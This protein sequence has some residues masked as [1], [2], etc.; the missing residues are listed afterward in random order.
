MIGMRERLKILACFTLFWLAF[1]ILIKAIFL[2]YN[3][4]LTRQLTASEIFLVFLYGL[5]MDASMSGYLLMF[6]S[7][8]LTISVFTKSKAIIYIIN[9]V[10]ILFLFIS[11]AVVIVDVELYRHWGFRL[12]TTPLLYIGPEA[13]GSIEPSVIIKNILILLIL[14]IGFL[15]IYIT[16]LIP[17]LHKLNKYNWKVFSIMLVITGLLFIPIRG[18]FTVAPMNTGFVYFHNTKPYANHAA[19]NVVWNFLKSVTRGNE[20]RYPENFF[21]KKLATTYF[22]ELYTQGDSTTSLLNTRKPNILLFVLESFTADV[23]EPLG[24]VKDITPN[25]NKLCREGILFDNFYASGDRTDK[26]IVSILSGYP[27]QPQSSIIKFPSKTQHL[28]YLTRYLNDLGYHTSFVYGGDIDFSN[29]RSYLTNCQFEHITSLDDLPDELYTS[30]W[31]IHD[32]YVFGQA[33]QE[34][35]SSK[36]PFFKIVLSL[37]SHEPFDV[38]MEPVIKGSDHESLFLNSCY[39]TDKSLGDFINKAKQQPWWSN[40]LVIITADHG[41]RLPRNKEIKDK[42][43]FRIPLL[44]IGG[45]LN[46]RD[47]IIHTFSNQTDIAN[48]LLAQL[49]IPHKEFNFSKNILSNK[50]NSFAVYFYN[51]GYGFIKPNQYI[52]YDNPGKQFLKSVNASEKDL[53]VSQAYQQ[54]LFEDYNKK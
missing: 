30:K 17:P 23:I 27:A 20:V 49:D 34:C 6:T 32:H 3:H 22:N 39:Y 40:T 26:G 10:S 21:D 4:D 33:M 13:M 12:N 45:A 29:F 18:S 36:N 8:M 54:V 50:V 37:S 31:G 47:T 44:L 35:D 51:D 24:G 42:E 38:P 25:L 41:H 28:P 11:C 9:T 14:F 5:K 53:G 15:F 2:V 48:T 7:L 19:I 52:I 1:M 46:K 16:Y 43:R